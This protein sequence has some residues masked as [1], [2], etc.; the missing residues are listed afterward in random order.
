[1]AITIGIKKIICLNT[2]PETDFDLIKESG[3]SI[4]MLDKN[5]IQYW[6]KSLLNL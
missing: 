6:T 4:E 3:I 5:R 1:M 2:Y